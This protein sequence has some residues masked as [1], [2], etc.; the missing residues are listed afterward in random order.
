MSRG[1]HAE[2][3]SAGCCVVLFEPVSASLTHSRVKEITMQLRYS[4]LALVLTAGITPSV[5][6][7]ERP[8]PAL[9]VSAGW[10]GF[11]DESIIH[12]RA[13]GAS[14]RF[15]LAPQFSVGPEL[16]YMIG[17][18]SDRDVFLLAN[19]TYEWPLLRA[20]G[21]PRVTPFVIGGWG[22]MRHRSRFIPFVAHSSAYAGGAGV[23]VRV[24]DRVSAGS[25]I[26]FG[27]ELHMRVNGTVTLH[28]GSP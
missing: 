11:A 28:V 17:P 15:Y 12:H 5:A 14:V 23:R 24:T 26:R 4:V 10:A 7:Q 13:A 3:I 27:S 9:D 18:G 25:E 6:A 8:S 2:R 1:H 20:D 16:T 22:Y 19:A 21:L